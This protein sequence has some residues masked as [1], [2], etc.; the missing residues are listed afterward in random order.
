MKKIFFLLLVPLVF[1]Q[2]SYSQDFDELIILA[3]TDVH[4]HALPYD[5]FTGNEKKMGLAKAF[6]KIKEIRSK[7]KNTLLLDSG[8]L[9]QGTPLV[10]YYA[11]YEK[12]KINP[13]IKAMNY[14]GYSAMGVGN[15]EY[16]YGLDNLM[17]ASKDAKFDFLSAN[18]YH[19]N[20]NKYLFKPYKIENINGLKIGIIGL[21]TPGVSVWSKNIVGNKYYFEDIVTATEKII[22]EVK[23]KSDIVVAI[24][25]SGL[26]D[27]EGKQ[28][29]SKDI[30][31]PPENAGKILA[32][33]INKLDIIILGHSHK[34][35]KEL[36]VNN[37]LITQPKPF[38]QQLSFIKLKIDKKSKR[39][40]SKNSEIIELRDVLPSKEIIDLLSQEH[41]KTVNYVNTPISFSNEELKADNSKFEDTPIID[42]IN[43]VQMEYTKAD[44]S[45]TSVFNDKAY[46]PKGDVKISNIA[47]LYIYENTLMAVRITG[48]KLKEYL[49]NTVKFYD[50]KNG[51]IYENKDIPSYNYDIF[52]GIEYTIDVSKP[53]GS[54]IIELKFKGKNVDDDMK[55]IL[56]LN[57]YR[58]SGGGG[59]SILKDCEIVYSKQESI[60]DLIIEYLKKKKI[61]DKKDFF[62][63]NWKIVK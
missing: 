29:Y 9:L 63:K 14:M 8:D 41:N 2:I 20:T 38:A 42:L 18:T 30:G 55:F 6:T 16:D 45:A 33:K 60:R 32:E 59:Y 25:H 56:A 17:K 15:H 57:N 24:P 35:I 51:E 47:G 22:D 39:I 10:E 53:I 27:E 11:K 62:E 21:T 37:V 5:Y 54:R 48:K 36:F 7:Y 58:Q 46:I 34:E 52:S 50:Y 13:M 26:E 43:K 61:L 49:E 4:G 3:T 40:L 44:I 31:L 1:N 19:L 23:N 12:N 28:G